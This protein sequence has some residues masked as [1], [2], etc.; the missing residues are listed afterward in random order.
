MRLTVRRKKLQSSPGSSPSPPR[1]DPSPGFQA[2]PDPHITKDKEDKE[3]HALRTKSKAARKAPCHDASSDDDDYNNAIDPWFA[4]AKAARQ[5][6]RRKASSNVDDE[7]DPPLTVEEQCVRLIGLVEKAKHNKGSGVATPKVTSKRHR[8][9]EGE[10]ARKK[11]RKGRKTAGKRKK[12]KDEE[13]GGQKK[14]KKESGNPHP[15]RKGA[16]DMQSAPTTIMPRLKPQLKPKTST[17]FTPG[18]STTSGTGAAAATTDAAP[19]DATGTTSGAP[20]TTFD[21]LPARTTS[22]ED[23]PPNSSSRAASDKVDYAIR[24]AWAETTLKKYNCSLDVFHFFCDREHIAGG[25]AASVMFA[26]KAWH[27]VNDTPWQRGVRLRY[28]LKGVANQAPVSSKQDERPPVT[29]EMMDALEADLNHNDLKDAAVFAMA[30]C[31]YWGQIWLG[32]MLSNVQG[33]YL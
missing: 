16:A 33:P 32:E 4:R 22:T 6:T 29:A 7:N 18:I 9:E 23:A 26:V 15:M 20:T 28:T 25:T 19:A 10:G 17:T 12:G 2:R 14:K 21:A 5:F 31:A 13:E 3:E 11:R 1:P 24:H 30:C 8:N 27:I